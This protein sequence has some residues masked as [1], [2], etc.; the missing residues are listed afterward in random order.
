MDDPDEIPLV[1]FHQLV[2]GGLVPQRADRSAGGLLSTRAFR[3]CEAV[4][5]ASAFGWYVFPP[6]SFSLI[7][8]GTSVRWSFD[9]YDG[10]LP[11]GRAQFPHFAASFDE[12]A[13]EDVRGFSP[14]FLAAL[15]EPGVVQVW[16]GLMA[17]SRPGWSLLLRPPANLPKPGAYEMFEGIVETDRWF[18]PLFTNVRLTK[19]DVPILF[20]AAYPLYQI[21][22]LPRSLYI[23]EDLRCVDRRDGVEGMSEVDWIDYR[24][25]VMKDGRGGDS[26]FGGDAVE[27]RR[28]RKTRPS[29]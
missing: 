9:G 15:P 28:R 21:Q 17:R 13:P 25:T 19:T 1:R 12:W 11:L 27:V 23:D 18:G 29:T 5:T 16:P 26:P 3:F 6:I 4:T 7:W 14:P 24:H 10:W 22:P 8:D 2:G 20:D